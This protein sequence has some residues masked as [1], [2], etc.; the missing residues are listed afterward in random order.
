MSFNA[1]FKRF[2]ALTPPCN[3]VTPKK[4]VIKIEENY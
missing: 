4:K 2:K 3:I 1:I